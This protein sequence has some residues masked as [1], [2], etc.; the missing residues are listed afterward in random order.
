MSKNKDDYDAEFDLNKIIKKNKKK[1]RVLEDDSEEK[2]LYLKEFNL[3]SMPPTD[4]NDKNGV[5]IV[6]IGKPGTGKSTI[7]ADI[8]ASKSHIIPV[9][10]VFSG[11]EDSNHFYSEKIPSVCIFNKLD[12]TAIEQFVVRQKIAKQY[13]EVPWAMQIIDDCTDNPRIFKEPVFQSYYKNGRHWKMLHILSLQYSMDIPPAIR[14]N[15]DYTFILRESNVSNREKLHK[16]Y[17]SCIDSLSE[18]NQIMDAV[19]EDYTALVICNRVQSNK[20]EDCVFWY[21]ADPNRLPR[22]WK[23]GHQ[24]FWEHN[25]DRLDPNYRDPFVI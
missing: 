7:I 24:T 17:A 8:I 21:K 9:A 23:F 20:I 10:Q 15:I 22:N 12:M 18:F 4:I 2:T 11:T 1:S 6:V 19:T 3:D 14:T 16:N 25:N 13:L 5:K